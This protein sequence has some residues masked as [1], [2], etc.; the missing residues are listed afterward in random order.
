MMNH[1]N[2]CMY[3]A[4]GGMS[5]GKRDGRMTFEPFENA[6]TKA[7]ATDWSKI[8]STGRDP[9]TDANCAKYGCPVGRTCAASSDCANGLSCVSN[10]CAKSNP[11][12][13]EN[14]KAAKAAAQTN[15]NDDERTRRKELADARRNIK[16]Q[17]VESTTA[18]SGG[19]SNGFWSWFKK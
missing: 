14:A 2:G 7:N 1:Y 13:K 15:G 19:S 10:K 18:T 16:T 5:C 9:S 12:D 17:P 11:F 6:P 8:A 4:A 3:H